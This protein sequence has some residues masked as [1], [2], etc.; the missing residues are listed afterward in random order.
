M[1]TVIITA[2]MRMASSDRAF[3]A[4]QMLCQVSYAF[5]RFILATSP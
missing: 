3:T 1:M 4:S 5:F 2:A